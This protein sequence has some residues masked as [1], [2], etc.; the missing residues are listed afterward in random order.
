[1]ASPQSATSAASR[2]GAPSIARQANAFIRRV[3]VLVKL[4]IRNVNAVG[5]GQLASPLAEPAG[6][7]RINPRKADPVWSQTGFD[8]PVINACC[9]KNHARNFCF[10]AQNA[11]ALSCSSYCPIS[12][13]RLRWCST[14]DPPGAQRYSSSLTAIMNVEAVHVSSTSRLIGKSK[15]TFTRSITT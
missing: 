13:L 7:T 12:R 3:S 14:H 10:F 9:F 11:S 1:M 5:F 4:D 15:P 2:P 6:L 8:A